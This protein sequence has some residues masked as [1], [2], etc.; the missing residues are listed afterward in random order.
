MGAYLRK[1]I[2]EVET[3][4]VTLAQFRI[5]PDF[6]AGYYAGLKAALE[7]MNAIEIQHQQELNDMCTCRYEG[8]PCSACSRKMTK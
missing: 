6:V 5:G 4:S 3:T 7:I 1:A 8:S 2:G